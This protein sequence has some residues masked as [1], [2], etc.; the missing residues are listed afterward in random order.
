MNLTKEQLELYAAVGAGKEVRYVCK[1]DIAFELYTGT[2]DDPPLG[3]D[4][5]D[6][7]VIDPDTITVSY[8]IPR[9]LTITP[10]LGGEYW[11]IDNDGLIE[12]HIYDDDNYEM[13]RCEAFNMFATKADA[14]AAHAARI[15][16]YKK[17]M[18]V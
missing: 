6:W 14:E 10:E 9:P 11:F 16:A 2:M 8:T 13:M 18:G 3:D 12:L 4:D 7:E 5:F 1:G 17:A 15:A